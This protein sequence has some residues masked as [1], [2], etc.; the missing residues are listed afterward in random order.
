MWPIRALAVTASIIFLSPP[1]MNPLI[2]LFAAR[3]VNVI[4]GHVL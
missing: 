2:V 4:I 3:L 1:K